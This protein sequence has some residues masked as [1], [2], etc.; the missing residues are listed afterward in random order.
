LGDPSGVLTS[1]IVTN[2]IINVAFTT[3]V[4]SAISRNWY[5]WKDSF[6]F[7][8]NWFASEWILQLIAGTFITTP[9]ILFICESSPKVIGARMNQLVAPLTS[10]LILILYRF[11]FPVRW[12]IALLLKQISNLVEKFVETSPQENRIKETEF[13]I[14]AEEGHREGN[15]AESE[16]DLIKKV[17]DLD[18][19]KI[20]NIYTPIDEVFSLPSH[21]NVEQ[22]MINLKNKDLSRIPVYEKTKDK[23]I[24]VIYLKDLLTAYID[25]DFSKK[26]LSMIMHKPYFVN[27]DTKLNA[28]FRRL[29]QNKKHMAIVQTQDKNIGIVTM[30]DILDEMFDELLPEEFDK[31]SGPKKIKADYA[32][33]GKGI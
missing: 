32:L 22:A 11:L 29:K 15:I 1:I 7:L 13:L 27:T 19:T 33:G 20:K 8:K 21:M 12:F 2:E 17:F 23:I 6:Y 31:P 28:L 16:L 30:R 25:P 4:E 9:I 14:L 26:N 3:I 18:D 10:R 5:R 24:G